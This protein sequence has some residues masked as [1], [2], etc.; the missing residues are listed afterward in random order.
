MFS[1]FTSTKD[2]S[3]GRPSSAPSRSGQL[4]L[5]PTQTTEPICVLWEGDDDVL[6][7]FVKARNKNPSFKNK[8]DYKMKKFYYY[9]KDSV[10]RRGAELLLD[11]PCRDIDRN[12]ILYGHNT[13]PDEEYL[14][15]VQSMIANK[16][17]EANR[18]YPSHTG[19]K[20]NTPG[21]P[22]PPSPSASSTRSPT[23]SSSPS[24]SSVPSSSSPSSAGSQVTRPSMNLSSPFS[25]SSDPV[26]TCAAATIHSVLTHGP[27]DV[28]DL[29]KENQYTILSRWGRIAGETVRLGAGK[30]E[31][32]DERPD[33]PVAPADVKLDHADEELL[34]RQGYNTYLGISFMRELINQGRS[35]VKLNYPTWSE[36]K[37]KGTVNPHRRRHAT[38]FIVGEVT[39]GAADD[40]D[41]APTHYYILCTNQHVL[42]MESQARHKSS[43]ALFD[44]DAENAEHAAHQ[45]L[46]RPDVFWASDDSDKGLDF[47]L[48]AC[49]TPSKDGQYKWDKRN[50]RYVWHAKTPRPIL[51]F[52][53]DAD[54]K[55]IQEAESFGADNARVFLIHHAEGKEKRMSLQGV[56]IARS[57][58]PENHWLGC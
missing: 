47:T 25:L 12:H 26:L 32:K 45:C 55:F 15:S 49:D 51:K 53:P 57:S 39:V 44:F 58:L 3:F 1:S 40:E 23:S 33:L 27:H 29:L 13:Q 34:N 50:H 28:H 9:V 42:R 22:P 16:A 11:T 5:H 10:N 38:A 37:G 24:S 48:V 35:V 30:V 7:A 6:D 8:I 4:Y 14:Q 52:R 19:V 18:A 21:P 2:E 31:L 56:R 36:V 54:D 43:V 20:F 46:L 41:H 17:V